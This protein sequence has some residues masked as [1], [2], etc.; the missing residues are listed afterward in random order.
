MTMRMANVD[1]AGGGVATETTASIASRTLNAFGRMFRSKCHHAI[2]F[3]LDRTFAPTDSNRSA[4]AYEDN[5][6]KLDAI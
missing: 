5:P 4:T 3:L 2:G 6:F 1:Q